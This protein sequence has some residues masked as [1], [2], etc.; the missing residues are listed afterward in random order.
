MKSIEKGPG[1]Q[2]ERTILYFQ[3]S[4][5]EA[6]RLNIA[7]LTASAHAHGWAVQI[8]EMPAHD[9]QTVR[10]AQKIEHHYVHCAVERTFRPQKRILKRYSHESAV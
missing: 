4:R 6:D 10:P 3:E 1:C 5:C 8:L 7:G 2:R 9:L